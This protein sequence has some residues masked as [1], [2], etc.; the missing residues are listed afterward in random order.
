MPLSK[1]YKD[2]L[3]KAT[4]KGVVQPLETMPDARD[5]LDIPD[6]RVPIN[7]TKLAE[8]MYGN[9]TKQFKENQVTRED[10]D[11]ARD[12]SR[13]RALMTGFSN[14]AA[15]AGGTKSIFGETARAL[16]DAQTIELNNRAKLS[17]QGLGNV[18]ASL[19]EMAES[20]LRTIKAEQLR[21]QNEQLIQKNKEIQDS[22]DPNS[23]LSKF[24]RDYYRTLM[25]GKSQLPAT[26]SATDLAKFS[27]DIARAAAAEADRKFKLQL[28]G[29]KTKADINAE[30]R[31]RL[32]ADKKGDAVFRNMAEPD[33][34]EI[35]SL[36]KST[37][38]KKSLSFQIKG[39]MEQWN[40]SKTDA[41]KTRIGTQMVKLI[42]SLQG[43]DAVGVEEVRRLSNELLFY[44]T[45]DPNT[46]LP[47]IGR[48]DLPGFVKRVFGV[49]SSLDNAIKANDAEV[50]GIYKQYS[51]DGGA[52]GA[53]KAQ[54]KEEIKSGNR[55]VWTPPK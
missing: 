29:R 14:A 24:S 7:Y 38:F 8:D 4:P 23:E 45:L 42:N 52:F 46:G 51:P 31:R 16:D 20:P 32:A 53:R 27:P 26:M 17:D 30:D 47:R 35:L 15:T 21:Q 2:P 25:P 3:K 41:D 11:S 37:A 49:A 39:F 1:N 22:N 54:A 40:K 34:Q 12:Q 13:L 5:P 10:I 9:A 36:S 55:K 28:L 48:Q 33:K 19:Q 44:T 50:L 6:V 18:K 43:P